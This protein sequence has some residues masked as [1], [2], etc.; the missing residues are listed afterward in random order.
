MKEGKSLDDI[1]NEVK[2]AEYADWG[3]QERL[4]TNIDDAYRALAANP[5][6]LSQGRSELQAT[7]NLSKRC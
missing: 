5:S 3:S 1:K 2:M 4:P 7:F 6:A